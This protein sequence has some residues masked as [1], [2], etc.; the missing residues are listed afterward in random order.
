MT[1]RSQQLGARTRGPKPGGN[2]EGRSASILPQL[3]WEATPSK[4]R[5]ACAELGA[6]YVFWA[7]NLYSRMSLRRSPR[8]TGPSPKPELPQKPRPPKRVQNPAEDSVRE[9]NYQAELAQ[10]EADK[11]EH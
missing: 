11:E 10:W 5:T 6:E 1:G 8:L 2:H 3:H 7:Q 9:A 4:T